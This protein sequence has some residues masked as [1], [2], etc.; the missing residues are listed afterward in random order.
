MTAEQLFCNSPNG[1]DVAV[2]IVN[3]GTAEL[4]V[5]AIE[6]VI[7]RSHGGRS[8]EMHLVDNASP[9]DDAARLA[10]ALEAPFGAERITFYP[11]KVNH[12][13]GRGNNL[14]LKALANSSAPPRYVLLLNPDARLDNEVIQILA[15]FLDSH[16]A[17]TCAG[18]R[19]SDPEGNPATAA[20]RFPSLISEFADTLAFGPVA[21]LCA[22]WT[23]PLSPV[24]DTMRVDWVSGAAVMFRFEPLVAAGGFDSAFFLYF[25]EVD[26]M[27]RLT[28]A[29]GEVWHV[30]EAHVLHSEGI[31]T[32][33]RGGAGAPLRR[34]DYW[35]KSWA[36][37]FRASH[38]RVGGVAAAGVKMSAGLLNHL[39][40]LLRRRQPSLPAGFL[41]DFP[42]VALPV[43][44]RG[45]RSSR[46][47]EG[48]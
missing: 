21:R 40:A 15:D 20:F 46:S 23:V 2:I 39:I 24:I 26:L 6:S 25:E 10:R 5:Q 8:V 32:G 41:R 11:E 45:V 44:L 4:A 22:D 3:Y 35:Y 28:A 17:A 13:F 36:H 12:G 9:G 31:A 29:G 38:G 14:V 48:K 7:A 37:Y 16:P 18:A 30:S 27:R 42:R 43:L 47:G 34:P 33:I 1:V 19:I